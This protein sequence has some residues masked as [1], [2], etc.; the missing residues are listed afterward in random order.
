MKNE[1][2]RNSQE[3]VGDEMKS[4]MKQAENILA[5]CRE[6]REKYIMNFRKILE[7]QRIKE[8]VEKEVIKVIKTNEILVKKLV[9]RKG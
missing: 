1:N 6:E 3:K 5:V 9:G 8:E 4:G 2:L 7:Q